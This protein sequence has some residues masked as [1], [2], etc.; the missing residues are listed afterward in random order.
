MKMFKRFSVFSFLLTI[1]TGAV[2]AGDWV[3]DN[4]NIHYSEGNVGINTT[5]PQ[6]KLHV[7]GHIRLNDGNENSNSYIKGA[8]EKGAIN[9]V[10]NNYIADSH[11][12]ISL[13]GDDGEN[14]F[15]KQV[16]L[17]G[18]SIDF[19]VNKA[20]GNY[21]TTA[22]KIF[23]SGLTT[24]YSRI[25]F[26]GG[27]VVFQKD[28]DYTVNDVN[29][30]KINRFRIGGDGSSR[31]AITKYDFDPAL[32]TDGDNIYFSLRPGAKVGI[33]T[34][35]L[36]S[37]LN[38]NGDVRI[39]L[40]TD[41]DDATNDSSYG[42]RLYF[43]GGNDWSTFNS[44]NSDP[45]WIARYNKA[46]D[47]TELRINIGDHSKSTT[48]QFVVGVTENGGQQWIPAFSVRADGKV[49]VGTDDPGNN[50]LTVEGK[51]GA[52]EIV[53]TKA[54]WS[55]YVFED[56]YKLRPLSAVEKYIEKNKHLPDIPSEKEI[57][58]K[59][60]AMAEMMALQMKK[61]EELTLY[62]IE[63]KKESVKMNDKHS[64]LE[65]E[66]QE[67]KEMNQSILAHLETLG[68]KIN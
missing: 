32:Y 13:T 20:P 4:P 62:M 10:Q 44:D 59:G 21:G 29:Y 46:E 36:T 40:V 3:T 66:N 45:L 2:L 31:F 25:A 19:R 57:K 54:S 6:D 16:V 39:G 23:S 67:L 43:S 12:A 51:I 5:N 52:R 65:K 63:M 8:A 48:D 9:L 18:N 61:I 24:F 27:A 37:K 42:D 30:G 17:Y 34:T 11:A 58:E 26:E 64:K 33:G 22:M 47:Q 68:D 1:F 49:A 14:K 28:D 56:S 55:D 50:Q 60:L 53:V 35:K 15:W 41:E 7:S 38:V